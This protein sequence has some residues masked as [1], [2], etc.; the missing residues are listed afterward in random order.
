[1]INSIQ[2][3]YSY[4]ALPLPNHA[5]CIETFTHMR[6]FPVD[7]GGVF[8]QF[9]MEE[10]EWWSNNNS[11]SNLSLQTKLSFDPDPVNS[12]LEYL[13]E[14][15]QEIDFRSFRELWF[16]LCNLAERQLW[17]LHQLFK[18]DP[19][20]GARALMQR[21][22]IHASFAGEVISVWECRNVTPDAIHWSGRVQNICYEYIPVEYQKQLWFVSPGS[23]DLVSSSPVV[24]CEHRIPLVYKDIFG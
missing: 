17:I 18:I 5:R 23:Q 6:A 10:P 11:L 19:T 3:A 22:D 15:V 4:S 24:D 9:P 13:M 16:H 2:A 1:M 14:K 20:L 8:L 12:K 21:D 7:Q